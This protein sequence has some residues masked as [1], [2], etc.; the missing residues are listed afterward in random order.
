M[1]KDY[2]LA[3]VVLGGLRDLALK[4]SFDETKRKQNI[5]KAADDVSVL[6][7]ARLL[8]HGFFYRKPSHPG[9]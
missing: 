5:I 8:L 7:R 4:I 1:L 9:N 2:I 3:F 6:Y